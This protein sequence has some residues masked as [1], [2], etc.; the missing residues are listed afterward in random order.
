MNRPA[1]GIGPV[2]KRALGNQKLATQVV[3]GNKTD[4][5]RSSSEFGWQELALLVYFF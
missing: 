5:D 1:P 2:S 3:D 4:R